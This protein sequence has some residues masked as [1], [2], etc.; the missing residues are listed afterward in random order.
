MASKNGR[1][2][3]STPHSC[4]RHDP[5]KSPVY[6]SCFRVDYTPAVHFFFFFYSPSLSEEGWQAVKWGPHLRFTKNM[7]ANCVLGDFLCYTERKRCLSQHQQ[8]LQPK[9]KRRKEVTFFSFPPSITM[10]HMYVLVV[11][12]ISCPSQ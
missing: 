7:G 8:T 10:F 1:K 2:Q 11:L 3:R 9:K 12:A 5:G 4:V 6:T